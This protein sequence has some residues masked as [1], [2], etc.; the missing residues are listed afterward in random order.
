MSVGNARNTYGSVAKTFHWLTALLILSAIPLGIIASNLAHKIEAPG[1]TPDEATLALTATLFSL[2]K[3]IGVTVFFVALARIAWAL[4]QPKPGLLNG[5]NGVEAW[6]AETVHWLLYGSLVAVPLT[7]WIHHAATTG[8]APIWWPFGQSLPF[9][10]KDLHLADLFG[11]LHYVLQWVLVA[12]V[13]LHIVGATKHHVI[14]KDATL[15]RMLPGQTTAE[16]TEQQP[17]HALPFVTALA[18]WAGALGGAQALGWFSHGHE[19]TEA[20][21]TLEQ[22]E[23][24]WQVQEGTLSITVRQLGSDVT[25]QF[26]DWTAAISYDET[27]DDTGKHGNVTVTIATGSLTLGSVTSQA[28]GAGFLDAGAHPTAR[29]Q[30]DLLARDGGYVAMGTLNIRDQSVP[31]EMPFD[32]TID[33]GTANASGA[34]TVDRRDFSIGTDVKDEGSLG[35]AVEIRFDLTA[36]Q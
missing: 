35:F 34:L 19:T 32:L 17:N 24:D 2:H 4:T 21:A 15:R 12:S 11:T 31:V 26:A 8:F 20:A 3:T 25:G 9:V 13:S 1:A 28:T 29:F 14:D 33:R 18:L 5:D 36:T 16:P 22:V 23:S 6:L 30:A 27:P 10:P 7:G